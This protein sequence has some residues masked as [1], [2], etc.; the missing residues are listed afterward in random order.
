[1]R[2]IVRS[3]GR[4]LQ[5]MRE[6]VRLYDGE[7]HAGPRQPKGYEVVFTLPHPYRADADEDGARVRGV[8]QP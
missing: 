1:M 8:A 7:F 5:G 2:S 4:G 3:G 6:R